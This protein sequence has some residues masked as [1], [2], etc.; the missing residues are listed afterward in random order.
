V[1]AIAFRF[2]PKERWDFAGEDYPPA[3]TWPAKRSEAIGDMVQW[4]PVIA[5]QS[6]TPKHRGIRAVGS[7]DG[8]V[9][10]AVET[11][12][13]PTEEDAI[14]DGWV[15][16]EEY[17]RVW[18]GAWRVPVLWV[19]LFDHPI[20]ADQAPVCRPNPQASNPFSIT[21]AEWEEWK[22]VIEEALGKRL[23]L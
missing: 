19:H 13:L 17:K 22:C 2:N 10:S 14:R 4:M 12:D 3:D 20:P 11:W 15:S 1:A 18:L 9:V 8:G 6:G 21:N 23:T 7:V 5:W 16:L